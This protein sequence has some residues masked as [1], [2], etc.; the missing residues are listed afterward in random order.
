LRALDLFLYLVHVP[1]GG[2]ASEVAVA[3]WGAEQRREITIHKRFHS[4]VSALR[5][6]LGEE[7]ILRDSSASPGRYFLNPSIELD[8]DVAHF[9]R[10]ADAALSVGKLQ[11]DRIQPAIELRTDSYWPARNLR[12]PWFVKVSLHVEATYARLQECG[13]ELVR[14]LRPMAI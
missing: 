10:L 6:L 3:L 1:A 2:T 12:S 13:S 5:Q 8:Y 14:D 9:L 7:T 4:M 11:L